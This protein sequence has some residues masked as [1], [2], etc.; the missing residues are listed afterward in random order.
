MYQKLFVLFQ[1]GCREEAQEG[2]TW[3]SG[4]YRRPG[5][6]VDNGWLPFWP[7]RP[8]IPNLQVRPGGY[9][10]LSESLTH[11]WLL[12]FWD[13]LVDGSEGAEGLIENTHAHLSLG[14][15]RTRLL[16]YTALAVL[17]P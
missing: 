5:A 8:L 15:S 3:L 1:V 13:T 2:A 14:L 6:F 7:L 9:K 4:A 12:P 17:E 16:Y 11:H 10:S